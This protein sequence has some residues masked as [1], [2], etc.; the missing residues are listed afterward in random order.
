MR[1]RKPGRA[2]GCGGE[3]FFQPR[4]ADSDTALACI[5]GEIRHAERDFG[6]V[7]PTEALCDRVDLRKTAARPGDALGDGEQFGEQHE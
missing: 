6:G 1:E 5:A 2:C 3:G 7:E 4:V